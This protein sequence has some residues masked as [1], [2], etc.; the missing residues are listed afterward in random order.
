MEV[1]S[2]VSRVA[3]AFGIG[4]LM[5]LERGWSTRDATAGTRAAGVRTFAISGLLGGLVGALARGSAGG[6][7]LEGSIFLGA[8]FIAFAAVIALFGRE[9]NR[10]AGRYSAT[11]TIAALLTFI[12]GAYAAIGDVRIAAGAAVAAAAVL[13]FREGLHGWVARITRVEFESALLLLAMTFIALPIVPNGSVGPLGGVNL[14]EVWIIAIALAAVSFAGYV[15]VKLLGERRGVLVAAAAGGLVSSTAVAFS[16]A[17]RAAAGE[18]SARVL[19]AGTALATAVSFARVTAIAGVLSPALLMLVAPAL[20]VSAAVA[21]GFALIS[22]NSRAARDAGEGR[23]Q[24]RNPFGFWAVLGMAVTMGVLILV[25]RFVNAK[26]GAAGAVAG[27]V[28]M[29]LFD[30]DAMTVSMAR[31]MPGGPNLHVVAY[32]LLAGVASNTVSKVAISAVIGR[33][34]FA[35]QIAALAVGCLLSGWLALLVTV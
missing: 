21:A 11:S 34:W 12:L 15:A 31:L 7:T 26:F 25:G 8:A 28:A 9:E 17:R 20:L 16:N 14:R 13:I 3:L 35:I 19:A 10:A 32:A 18:G 6:V 1:E 2:Q 4:L 27:A 5:G 33:G 22:V 29:G 24:F 30:V 23:V